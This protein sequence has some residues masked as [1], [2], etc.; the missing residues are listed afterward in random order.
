MMRKE[1]LDKGDT[2]P[3][4]KELGDWINNHMHPDLHKVHE[5][6][7]MISS[8]VYSVEIPILEQDWVNYNQA[9]AHLKD[10]REYHN[11]LARG[12]EELDRVTKVHVDATDQ[13]TWPQLT[14]PNLSLEE[15]LA[16][17]V[18]QHSLGRP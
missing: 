9:L 1:C 11:L 18:T 5:R 10:A 17:L 13:L 8:I 14:V 7:A 16:G 15:M 6:D 2:V 3:G 4:M 12:R